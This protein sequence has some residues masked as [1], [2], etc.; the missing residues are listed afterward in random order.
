MPRRQDR[1]VN[2]AF[3]HFQGGKL[4]G[5]S[6]TGHMLYDVLMFPNGLNP[7]EESANLTFRAFEAK[8]GYC[9]SKCFQPS[10]SAGCRS[11]PSVSHL[12]SL[13][14]LISS[15]NQSVVVGVKNQSVAVAFTGFVVVA[16]VGSLVRSG[17]RFAFAGFVAVVQIRGRCVVEFVGSFRPWRSDA[18]SCP[19]RGCRSVVVGRPLLYR[20]V[21][22]R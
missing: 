7:S 11:I 12:L 10:A 18:D 16:F 1:K 20:F 8:Q 13:C 15:A 9:S 19:W 21:A 22:G 5:M 3:I 14:H 2:G 4:Y 17:R 6:I